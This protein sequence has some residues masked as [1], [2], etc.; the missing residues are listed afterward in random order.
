MALYFNP[1]TADQLDTPIRPL[2]DFPFTEDLP[3]TATVTNRQFQ[4]RNLK[5]NYRAFAT[6]ATQIKINEATSPPAN[7][8]QA[9]TTAIQDSRRQLLRIYNLIQDFTAKI[10][11]AQSVQTATR[12]ALNLPVDHAANQAFSLSDMASFLRKASKSDDEERSLKETWKKAVYYADTIRISHAQ[13]K[14]GLSTF[15]TGDAFDYLANAGTKTLKTIAKELAER[16]VTTNEFHESKRKLDTFTR[17]PNEKLRPTVQRLKKLIEQASLLHPEPAREHIKGYILMQK[18]KEIISPKAL[19]RLDYYES[20]NNREGIIMSED[21]LINIADNEEIRSGVPQTETKIKIGLY[22]VEAGQEP[23]AAQPAAQ[24]SDGYDAINTRLDHLTNVLTNVVLTTGLSELNDVDFTNDAEVH[25][26]IKK[27]KFNT[28]PNPY[29]MASSNKLA[30]PAQPFSASQQALEQAQQHALQQAAMQAAQKAYRPP[31]P[32]A[33]PLP[34][35]DY[36]M[37]VPTYA[38]DRGRS[39]SFSKN[40][41]AK[42]QEERSRHPSYDRFLRDRSKSATPRERRTRPPSAST[43]YKNRHY[44]NL[45]KTNEQLASIASQKPFPYYSNGYPR[46]KSP[47]N[48]GRPKS[49][50]NPQYGG[51]PYNPQYGAKPHNVLNANDHSNVN[52]SG[53]CQL[54]ARPVHTNMTECH[55]LQSMLKAASTHK[56]N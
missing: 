10:Q 21:E 5:E 39:R 13:F 46:D 29:A 6:L 54:C 55:V 7:R 27:V 9:V 26:A 8:P 40:A 47:G 2:P 15:L 33:A 23:Q 24:N 37:N 31:T 50:F 11:A 34:D 44:D 32:A 56:E 12:P 42:M 51:K 49:P 45:K 35:T 17:K 38:S 14:L 25:A 41:N 3:T 30:K 43:F 1:L 48:T 16:F 52:I 22:N 36:D 4:L 18:I 28:R 53:L 20:D 19:Q